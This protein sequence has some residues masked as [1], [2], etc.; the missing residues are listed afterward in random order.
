MTKLLFFRLFR[1]CT[2]CDLDIDLHIFIY[3]LFRFW[4]Q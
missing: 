3:H 2:I 1:K 4:C